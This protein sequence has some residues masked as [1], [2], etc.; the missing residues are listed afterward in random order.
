MMA[1]LTPWIESGVVALVALGAF[2]AGRW[3]SR[4]RSPYWLIGYVLPLGLVLLYCLAE[5]EPRLAV[6]P[7]LSWMM[8]GR[9]KFVWFNVV[10][11][12]VLSTPLG[13][14][15]QRR[16]RVMVGLLILVLSSMSVVPF[17]APAFN[18]SYLAGLRTRID[19][20]GVCRQSRFR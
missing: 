15:A 19:S 7:P 14:L 16:N 5:L 17:L 10:T 3:C 4:L 6:V 13:R 1:S 12:M 18:R 20:D 8:I 11:T 9:G 2:L